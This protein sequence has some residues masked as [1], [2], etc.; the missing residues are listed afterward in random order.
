[1]LMLVISGSSLAMKRSADGDLLNQTEGKIQRTAEIGAASSAYAPAASSSSATPASSAAASARA[2]SPV[3]ALQP[4]LKYLL[5]KTGIDPLLRTERVTPLDPQR[6]SMFASLQAVMQQKQQTL[7]YALALE[8]KLMKQEMFM[9]QEKEM[10]RQNLITARNIKTQADL[11]AEQ[12]AAKIMAKQMEEHNQDM[13]EQQKLL[14]EHQKRM[15]EKQR[16]M[17]EQQKLFADLTQKQSDAVM[18]QEAAANAPEERLPVAAAASASMQNISVNLPLSPMAV[19]S[20]SASFD[21]IKKKKGRPGRISSNAQCQKEIED[22]LGK[23][24]DSTIVTDEWNAAHV[25]YQLSYNMVR[26]HEKY[27]QK[28]N[29]KLKTAQQHVDAQ[30]AEHEEDASSNTPA[31][32]SNA[33]A[34]SF[35]ADSFNTV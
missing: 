32:S 28:Q 3:Q 12:Q 24:K 7:E 19:A 22:G 18:K 30:E 23:G 21:S 13:A 8:K 14:E 10:V 17:A 26:Y 34:S 31:S 5:A 27:C 29:T 6:F 11:L 4:A 35:A 2:D 9:D 25:D 16:I 33:P 15:A 1:M 20:S